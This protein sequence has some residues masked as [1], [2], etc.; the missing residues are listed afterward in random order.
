MKRGLSEL[1]QKK[2]LGRHFLGQIPN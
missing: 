1:I 2:M